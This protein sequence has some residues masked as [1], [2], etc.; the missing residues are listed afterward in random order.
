MTVKRIILSIVFILCFLYGKSQS[1]FVFSENVDSIE[2][3][4]PRFAEP[5]SLNIDRKTWQEDAYYIT[6]CFKTFKFSTNNKHFNPLSK[7]LI[8][9]A[10]N[11]IDK[12]YIEKS[13]KTYISRKKLSYES[14]YDLINPIW[15]Q[16]YY[17]NKQSNKGFESYELNPI[18]GV[19]GYEYEYCPDFYTLFDLVQ[20]IQKSIHNFFIENMDDF[21]IK[22][23]QQDKNLPHK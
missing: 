3:S 12:F 16:I 21:R 22:F 4:F 18:Q 2:F 14:E 10:L 17:K 11:L 1:T 8:D 9:S 23:R 15:V 6:Y 5:I 13:Q 20:R 7:Q 19:S